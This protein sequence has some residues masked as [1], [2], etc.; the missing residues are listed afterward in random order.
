M[1]PH[2]A[3]HLGLSDNFMIN[4]EDIYERCLAVMDHA[5]QEPNAYTAAQ[6]AACDSVLAVIDTTR[7]RQAELAGNLSATWK[8]LMEAFPD[9]AAFRE[10]DEQLASAAHTSITEDEKLSASVNLQEEIQRRVRC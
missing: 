2:R 3:L 8:V 9:H 4:L 6:I 5:E 10:I 1:S 7:L